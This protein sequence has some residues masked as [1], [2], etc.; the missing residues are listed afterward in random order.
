MREKKNTSSFEICRDE[1]VFSAANF[2]VYLFSFFLVYA[3][4]FL[5][6]NLIKLYRIVQSFILC[7]N[8][9]KIRNIVTQRKKTGAKTP[10]TK[11]IYTQRMYR[12]AHLLIVH[13][14]GLL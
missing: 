9:I 14:I 7:H 13:F 2:F 8:L 10:N 1:I 4:L 12:C 3:M 11:Y 6:I 5:A